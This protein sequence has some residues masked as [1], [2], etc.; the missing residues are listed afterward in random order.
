MIGDHMYCVYIKHGEVMRH[1]SF[2]DALLDVID[3]MDNR[4]IGLTVWWEEAKD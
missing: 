2:I 1:R 4:A 3:C